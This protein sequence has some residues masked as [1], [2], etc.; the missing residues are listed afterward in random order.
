[1]RRRPMILQYAQIFT[2]FYILFMGAPLRRFPRCQ[3]ERIFVGAVC[4]LS[5]NIVSLFQSSLATVFIKPMYYKE[6]DTLKSFADTDK[7]ILIKYPAMM[8]DL[9][10]EDSS[11]TFNKLH[12]QMVLIPRMDM[13]TLD[14]INSGMAAVTRKINAKL[15][16]NRHLLH[17]IPE[18]PKS[19]NMA[20]L[21]KQNSVYLEPVNEV[22]LDIV[23]FGLMNKWI[24]DMIFRATMR[25]L[26]KTRHDIRAKSI[27][28]IQLQLPFFLLAAGILFS[29]AV[30]LFERIYWIY[31]KKR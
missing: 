2:D 23:Q 19:Y 4:L 3:S 31:S 27:N 18:C 9:F 21:L 29:F 15:F 12:H 20:Y 22:L 5:L 26:K 14:V 7:R 16:S 25:N 13:T 28:M 17:L 8:T 24:E 10:P 30:L 6:I 11:D 1:M